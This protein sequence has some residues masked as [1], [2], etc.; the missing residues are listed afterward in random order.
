ME[1]PLVRLEGVDFAYDGEPVLE[2]ASL[3]IDRGDFAALVGPNGGGKT[4]LLKL[5]LGLYQPH[6]GLVEVFGGP[7]A[8]VS[9]R[10]GYLP[11]RPEFDPLFP[12]T[13]LDVVL[14]GRLRGGFRPT[15]FHRA[16]HQAAQS[17]LEEVELGELAGRHFSRLSGGQRQRVLIARVLATHPELLLLDEPTAG[18]DPQA[19]RELFQLLRQLNRKLTIVLVSHDLFFVSRF[20]NKVICVKRTVQVHETSEVSDE[21]VTALYGSDLRL[22]RHAHHREEDHQP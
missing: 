8:E 6:R 16:D 5:I 15:F 12:V 1:T 17:A 10:I 7:P 4:T 21:T 20:V 2:D 14:M 11:Q 9:R 22:V 18:L 19:E 3:R 13:V